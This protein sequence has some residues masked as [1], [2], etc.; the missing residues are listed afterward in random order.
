MS[1]SGE[2]EKEYTSSSDGTTLSV[3][4][5]SLITSNWVGEVDCTSTA[6]RGAVVLVTEDLLALLALYRATMGILVQAHRQV[7]WCHV[8]A[9]TA[10]TGG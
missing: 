3:L 2:D 5:H 10:C 6:V 8:G 9:K 4:D 7:T 1:S